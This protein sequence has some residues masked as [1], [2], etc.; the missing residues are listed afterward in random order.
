MIAKAK[1]QNALKALQRILIKC[2][3]I[4]FEDGNKKLA[5]IM[6]IGEYLIWL[7]RD[8]DEERTLEFEN[9]LKELEERFPKLGALVQIL[10]E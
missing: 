6:D 5:E 3:S 2:R 10:D 9:N 7:I 4:A 1:Q 8:E